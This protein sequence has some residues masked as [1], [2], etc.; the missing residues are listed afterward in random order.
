M[1][2]NL[3]V[4]KE[5]NTGSQF[6]FFT[7]SRVTTHCNNKTQRNTNPLKTYK[8]NF[9]FAYISEFSIIRILE[10]HIYLV[11]NIMVTKLRERSQITLPANIVKKLNIKTGDNLEITLED[12]KIVIKPV[13]VIDR[14]QA[15]FWSKEWQDKE[16]EVERDIKAGKI[17]KADGYKDLLKKLEK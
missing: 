7:R 8:I 4:L 14:S 5:S 2:I 16:K 10:I 15:W 3:K 17:K 11:V 12:N 1:L 13:L 6:W 9:L